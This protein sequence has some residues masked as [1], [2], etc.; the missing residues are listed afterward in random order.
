MSINRNHRTAL[1]VNVSADASGDYRERAARLVES[2]GGPLG[3]THSAIKVDIFS[4]TPEGAVTR[5]LV[6]PTNDTSAPVD[7]QALAREAGYTQL[8]TASDPR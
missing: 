4:I 3:G 1:F 2:L 7:V 6:F 8:L 5:G